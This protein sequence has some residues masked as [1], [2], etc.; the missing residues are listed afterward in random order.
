MLKKLTPRLPNAAWGALAIIAILAVSLTFPSVRALANSFLG[1]FRVEQIRVI[2]FD[3]EEISEQLGSS[4]QL[5]QILGENIQFEEFGKPQV[6]ES[7]EQASQLAGFTVRAPSG[8]NEEP[9]L[10][11]QPGANM[12]FNANMDLIQTV[13]DEIGRS[14]IQL[15]AGLDG[16]QIKLDIPIGVTAQYGACDVKEMP[17]PEDE[18]FQAYKVQEYDCTTLI[19]VP[20]PTISAPPGLD[21]SIIGEAYLQVLGMS[22]EEAARF[23]QNVDW[24]TTFIVPIPQYYAENEDVTVDGVTGAY[25]QNKYTSKYVLLWVKEGIVHSLSGSGNKAQAVEI[26]NSLK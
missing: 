10:T 22:R 7:I 16:A 14:D 1:L 24:T 20:S 4:S 6:V 13:L 23:S 2:Q 26:A 19:Q 17:N 11:V 25:I 18:E 12:T 15:P 3:S 21:I 9:K 8:L 5:E